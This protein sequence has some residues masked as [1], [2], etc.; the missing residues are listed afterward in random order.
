MKISRR[1][2][3]LQALYLAGIALLG[4]YAVLVGVRVERSFTDLSGAVMPRLAHLQDIRF[5]VARF[6][7]STSEYITLGSSADAAVRSAQAQ[8][9]VEIGESVRLIEI[10]LAAYVSLF[11]PHL[12]AV[13]DADH[14]TA[15]RAGLTQLPSAAAAVIA[16][17]RELVAALPDHPQARDVAPGLERLQRLEGRALAAIDAIID[18]ETSELARRNGVLGQTVRTGQILV[19]AVAVLLLAAGFGLSLVIGRSVTRPLNRL[20]LA[21]T[22]V[23][24]GEF[25]AP[26][27]VHGGGEFGDLAQALRRMQTSLRDTT[28]SRRYVTSIFASMRESVIVTDIE[29][30][31]RF[32][33]PAAADMFGHAA[34]A[35]VGTD[36]RRLFPGEETYVAQAIVGRSQGVREAD[37]LTGSGERIPVAL[38]IDPLFTEQDQQ[39][40]AVLV[41]QDVRKRR[42]REAQLI[43]AKEQA[44]MADRTKSEF[45]ANMSHELRTPLNA[46]IGFSDLIAQEA[47][48]P[49]GNPKYREYV[50][51]INGAGNHLL[52]IISDILDLAK[53]EAG[54]AELQ[55][56]LID[57]AHVVAGCVRMVQSRADGGGVAIELNLADSIPPM[58]ADE[59]KLKQILLNLMTNAV[60][61]TPPGGKITVKAWLSEHDGIVLQVIDTGIGIAMNDI[62]KVLAPFG[63]GES[64]LAR[65]HEGTGL[66]LPLTKRLIELH[67]GS[68][69]LQSEASEGTTIT[70]R[71]PRERTMPPLAS[72]LVG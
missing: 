8:E 40:G 5:A 37:A 11:D 21:T 46:I 52:T 63:Q 7:G 58:Q 35:L 59:V 25:D 28:V 51:D 17:G 70:V 3:V 23:A 22:A 50:G 72:L 66:G 31:I 24:R 42:Q 2:A 9:L 12:A 1:L 32:V 49:I 15:D 10:G 64:A 4:L 68:M 6:V 53:I 60:K 30:C 71:F 57:V 20:C 54:E 48:G 34:A 16:A 41:A 26:V 56:R 13:E 38:S 33:N 27:D 39:T 61:F 47:L 55:E 44:E 69:N 43:A 45:L 19:P 62:P 18:L 14:R 67:S 65:S 29:G 36:I